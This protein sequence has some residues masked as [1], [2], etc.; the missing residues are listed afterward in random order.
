[1][2]SVSASLGEDTTSC[3]TRAS[4]ENGMNWRK[5]YGVWVVL[6]LGVPHCLFGDRPSVVELHVDTGAE[7]ALTMGDVNGD[8]RME[9]IAAS[10]GGDSPSCI[11][12][13]FGA[14]KMGR[15]VA[16]IGPEVIF[17]PSV[18]GFGPIW[19]VAGNFDG[20]RGDEVLALFSVPVDRPY[21]AEGGTWPGALP[22]RLEAVKRSEAW[23]RSFYR[24]AAG[25][26]GVFFRDPKRP[27]PTKG[28]FIDG[29]TNTRPWMS[30][31][32]TVESWLL[33]PAVE[34]AVGYSNPIALFPSDPKAYVAIG[35]RS[36]LLLGRNEGGETP[37]GRGTWNVTDV[38]DEIKADGKPFS[39]CAVGDLTG[40]GKA[41]IAWILKSGELRVRGYM[42]GGFPKETK[43]RIELIRSAQG[44]QRAPFDGALLPESHPMIGKRVEGQPSGRLAIG[45]PSRDGKNE[46]ILAVRAGDRGYLLSYQR[47]VYAPDVHL[48]GQG[49][50]DFEMID[51][52]RPGEF[53]MDVLIDDYNAD[54]VPE[55]LASTQRGHIYAYRRAEAGYCS[56]NTVML[57][58][59]VRRTLYEEGGLVINSLASGNMDGDD[60]NG[61][62]IAFSVFPGSPQIPVPWGHYLLYN[63]RD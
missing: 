34:G 47:R 54:G 14:E 29:W 40:D 25:P 58:D 20:R 39:A 27:F 44:A 26:I 33:D 17:F 35:N 56:G 12:Q 52:L 18:G 24:I 16:P 60:S 3:T 22:E 11:L 42:G 2:R 62:E 31:A 23:T 45:D 51:I 36:C 38:W 30:P 28:D 59:Y 43:S 10:K 50:W 6:L 21:G 5:L 13:V 15:V 4:E 57:H 9:V 61:R 1:M 53:F 19:L 55:I 63:T 37:P 46:L 32:W 7:H 48:D 8:G 41:E 49:T